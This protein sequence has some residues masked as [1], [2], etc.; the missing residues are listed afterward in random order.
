MRR[1]LRNLFRLLAA[2][3][4]VVGGMGFG[5]EFLR[6]RLRDAE[7][8]WTYVTG[9]ALLSALAIGLFAS[10]DRLAARLAD[11]ADEGDS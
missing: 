8:R 5:L 10:S 11:D 1:A 4:I 6:H 9:S 7:I 3:L 2:G